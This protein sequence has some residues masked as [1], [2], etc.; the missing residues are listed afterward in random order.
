MI[1]IGQWLQNNDP[2]TVTKSIISKPEIM[3]KLEIILIIGAV[4][5]LLMALLNVPLNALVVSVCF[6]M[7]GLLYLYLGFALFNGI[8]IQKIFDPESYKG[9]GTWRILLAVGTGVAL[10]EITIGLM[11][12]IRN[13][14]MAKSLMTFGIVLAAIMMILAVFK[15]AKEKNQFYRN[16][17]LRCL[18]FI[19]I[20]II[21]LV[22]PNHIF[23]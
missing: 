4:I 9:L 5:G 23:T 20:A 22:L 13:Y 10:S 8:P 1:E 18:I 6:L 15:N 7:L 14:P 2:V 3:K 11:F 17:I 21:F 19:V 12:T 16:I